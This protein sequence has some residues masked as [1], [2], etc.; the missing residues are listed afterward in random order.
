MGVKI[1]E[2][3]IPNDD[4]S[5]P[6]PVPF[7]TVWE[8]RLFIGFGADASLLE[9]VIAEKKSGGRAK[10][11]AIVAHAVSLA[12]KDAYAFSYSELG[13]QLSLILLQLRMMEAE[14]ESPE[15][16]WSKAPTAKDFPWSASGF[17]KETPHGQY[18]EYVL[19]RHSSV[20]E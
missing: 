11:N 5:M 10:G 8:G 18:S 6:P 2:V 13:S 17:S 14:S 7:Y 9:K 12:P 20:K 3:Q 4:A 16:D 15:I 1:N 19:F